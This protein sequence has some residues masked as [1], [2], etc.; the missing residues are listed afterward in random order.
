MTY[1]ITRVS[2]NEY[3]V[4]GKLEFTQ[5]SEDEFISFFAK[6]M[7]DVLYYH[8]D[9]LYDLTEDKEILS[10]LL[11]IM[12]ADMSFDE[13]VEFC[14]HSDAE[15]LVR[16][17]LAENPEIDGLDLLKQVFSEIDIDEDDVE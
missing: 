2:E 12:A 7:E 14:E 4:D 10:E 5:G 11:E 6:T 16:E 8:G 17:I 15:D 1:H 9:F 13:I 3:Q